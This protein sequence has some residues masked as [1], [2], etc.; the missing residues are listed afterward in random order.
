MYQKNNIQK[1]FFS[2][3]FLIYTAFFALIAHLGFWTGRYYFDYYAIKDAARNIFLEAH[4]KNDERIRSELKAKIS[5]LGT[6]IYDND[7]VITRKPGQV[8]L[9]IQYSEYLFLGE[10][11]LHKFNFLIDE[12]RYFKK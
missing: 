2:L 12:T 10:Y 5:N 7:I 8:N 3:K 1:G 6:P 4:V 9:K 11:S